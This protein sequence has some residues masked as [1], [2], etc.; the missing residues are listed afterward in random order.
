MYISK[1]Q[2]NTE[3]RHSNATL[4]FSLTIKLTLVTV[5]EKNQY[6]HVFYFKNLNKSFYIHD[7]NQP[8]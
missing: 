3:N 4:N 6:L 8:M 2:S 7:T 1:Q 5:L